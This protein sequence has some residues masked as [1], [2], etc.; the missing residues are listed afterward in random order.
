MKNINLNEVYISRY[1]VCVL[2]KPRKMNY[3]FLKAPTEA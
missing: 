2:R 3:N 1:V